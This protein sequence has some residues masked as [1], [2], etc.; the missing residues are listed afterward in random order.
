MRNAALEV[1]ILLTRSVSLMRKQGGEAEL[2]RGSQ[3]QKQIHIP[4]TLSSSSH[5]SKTCL[6]KGQEGHRRHEAPPTPIKLPRQQRRSEFRKGLEYQKMFHNFSMNPPPYIHS[7]KSSWFP[8]NQR[9]PT[10]KI[11]WP[12]T[13]KMHRQW[14]FPG[15][16]KE[17][18]PRRR[19]PLGCLGRSLLLRPKDEEVIIFH[20]GIIIVIHEFH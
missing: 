11:K 2:P 8:R 13:P 6:L 15:Q 14:F 20:I 12:S 5:Y 17:G 9:L 4:L 19:E 16:G 10:P 1:E 3:R 18:K 7:T